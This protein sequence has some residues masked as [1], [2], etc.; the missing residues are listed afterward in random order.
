MK[1]VIDHIESR[2][3]AHVEDLKSFVAIPSV[4]TDPEHAT[5]VKRCAEHCHDSLQD[6][7]FQTVELIKTNGHPIVYAEW[8]E[9]ENAPTVLFTAC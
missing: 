3:E 4:S 5:D 2:H 8:L 9:A 7:G 1:A 6:A